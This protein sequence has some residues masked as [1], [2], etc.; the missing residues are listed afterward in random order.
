M[1]GRKPEKSGPKERLEPTL[2]KLRFLVTFADWLARKQFRSLREMRA[3]GFPYTHAYASRTLAA[4]AAPAGGPLYEPEEMR[5]TA[6][7]QE[8]LSWGR[9]VLAGHAKWPPAGRKKVVVGT[10]NRVLNFVLP[11]AVVRFVSE[12]SEFELDLREYELTDM[13]RDLHG[14]AVQL[15]VGG[16]PFSEPPAGESGRGG[17][18]TGEY[19]GLRFEALRTS[20]PTVLIARADHERWG[21]GRE[22]R[23]VTFEDLKEAE[24]CVARADLAGALRPQLE[25]LANRIRLVV[26][27]FSSVVT[28]VRKSDLVGIVPELGLEAGGCAVRPFAKAAGMP[29]RRV[30]VW[31]R[32]RGELPEGA[33]RFA[34]AV[35]R[36]AR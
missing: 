9:G 15:G 17:E 2:E 8:Y 7:G 3:D 19:M 11:D 21:E 18:W 24:L 1:A 14:E 6:L 25:A 12:H 22:R 29:V 33:K 5:L 4:L 20:Y 27:N 31:T 23:V 34:E 32:L 28:V 36:Y 16:L 30:A 13:L 26:D 10:S 35:R